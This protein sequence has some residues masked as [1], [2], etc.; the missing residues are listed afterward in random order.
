M[1]IRGALNGGEF[2]TEETLWT[3]GRLRARLTGHDHFLPIP[4]NGS[5][6]YTVHVVT[7]QE[8]TVMLGEVGF[9]GPQTEIW[10]QP[11]NSRTSMPAWDNVAV[12]SVPEPG[13]IV[14]FALGVAALLLIRW[15]R[16]DARTGSR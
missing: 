14:T 3:N 12:V 7:A 16:N 11:A 5:T 10:S 13:V 15:W 1:T 6:T 2:I 9:A 8:T 4:S